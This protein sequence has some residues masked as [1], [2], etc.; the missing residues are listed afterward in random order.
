MCIPLLKYMPLCQGKQV[1][2]PDS[3]G[4]DPEGGS[5]V[6]A[7]LRDAPLREEEGPGRDRGQP[8]L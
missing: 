2:E 5:V 4:Q 3:A 1:R 6:P 7:V 8:R